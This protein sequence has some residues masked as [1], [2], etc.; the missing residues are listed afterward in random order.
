MF[1]SGAA[2]ERV[3]KTVSSDLTISGLG[4]T[5][6]NTRILQLFDRLSRNMAPTVQ[7]NPAEVYLAIPK[8]LPQSLIEDAK[9]AA[10]M[11]VTAFAESGKTI[12]KGSVEDFP[13]D[14]L[15]NRLREAYHTVIIDGKAVV[16]MAAV[17]ELCMKNLFSVAG[18]YCKTEKRNQI[19]KNDIRRAVEN[20]PELNRIF[21]G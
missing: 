21:E 9:N 20:D 7:M 18:D 15:L 12:E 16:A 17:M 10:D 1:L 11:A 4:L 6:L 5:D 8:A 14:D 19:G 2:A 3:L 13:L